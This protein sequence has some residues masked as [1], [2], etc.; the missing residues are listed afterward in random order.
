MRK[1]LDFRNS[2]ETK[3]N[4][5]FEEFSKNETKKIERHHDLIVEKSDKI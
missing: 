5:Y 3:E 1:I 2:M 4:N